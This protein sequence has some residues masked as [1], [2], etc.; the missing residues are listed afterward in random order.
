M[1]SLFLDTSTNLLYIGISKN[2]KLI[3]EHIKE[4]KKDHG[5]YLVPLIN[6]SLKSVNLTIDDI[7][8]IYV[9][10]G[11]GSY[12]GLRV[13]GMVAKMFS[14]LKE[15]PLYEVSSLYFLSSGYEGI[16][17]V[18][19]DARNNN[20]F[21]AVYDNDKTVVKEALRSI[22][23]FK[24]EVEKHNA[25]MILLDENNYK[26]DV[27]KIILKAKLVKNVDAFEPKYLRETQAER[28]L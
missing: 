18:M 14:S 16:K 15:I 25:K 7:D 11:P 8:K 17:A 23:D 1:K 9:G 4:G 26:I 24:V 12:T 13:S 5:Q 20:V 28:N 2:D 10:S 27:N 21:S 3:K 19:I 6:T 22:D